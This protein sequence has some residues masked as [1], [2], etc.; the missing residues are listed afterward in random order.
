MMDLDTLEKH[1]KDALA[2]LYDDLALEENPLVRTWPFPAG[3]PRPQAFRD[4]LRAHIRALRPSG[5]H[6]P[7]DAPAWRPYR[8]LQYRYLD[9]IPPAELPARLSLSERQVRRD[10]NRAVSLLARHL[11][12]QFS[13]AGFADS[14]M[15]QDFSLSLENLSL[16]EVWHGVEHMFASELR[17]R[18]GQVHASWPHPAPQVFADRVVL[19]QVLIAMLRRALQHASQGTLFLRTERRPGSVVLTLSA[20]GEEPPAS[21]YDLPEARHWSEKLGGSLVLVPNGRSLR[22]SLT[23]PAGETQAVILV[24]DD[25]R[26]ALRMFQR[27]LSRLPFTVIGVDNPHQVLSL[28]R[29]YRPVLITLDVMMPGLDGWELL[30]SLRMDEET[31]QIP[32]LVCSAWNEPELA[33]SLGAVAFLKKPITRQDL[34]SALEQIGVL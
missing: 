4:L 2:H 14:P 33:K 19:R 5:E 9:E 13:A 11:W 32:V 26:P 18:G 3:T 23:L 16:V 6:L 20:E 22:L 34:L 21:G 7:P 25:Q 28:A 10:H 30:Q 17:A 24:V 8:I 15:Q 29:Q 31:R 12:E 1:L 27:Y